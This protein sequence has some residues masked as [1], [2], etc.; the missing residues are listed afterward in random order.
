MAKFAD[1]IKKDKFATAI[2][3]RKKRP[4]RLLVDDS[5]NDDNSVVALSQQKMDELQL[6]RGDTVLLEGKKRRETICIVLADDNCSNER[7]LM[8]RVVRNNLRV[9]S[10]DIVSLQ[11]CSDA[12]DGKR[13]QVVPID[14]TVYGITRNLFE[15]YLKPYFLEAYR[16]VHEGDTF[17]TRAG[18]RAVEFKVIETDPS[19]Y[20]IVAPGTVIR[21]EGNPI[22]RTEEE[23]ASLNEIGFDDIGGLESVKRELQELIQYPVEHPEKFFKFG[24]RPSRGI[25]LYGPPGCGK[26]LLAKAIANE[27]QANFIS[28]KGPRL[29][30]MLMSGESETN[31]RDIFDEA[32]QAAPCILFFDDLDSIARSGSAS[33]SATNRV[34]N[35]ILTE[36]DDMNA[37]Q[38]VFIIGASNR[39]DIIDPA[40]LRSGRLD[41]LIYIPL[42]DENSRMGILKVALRKSPVARDVD[43][44]SLARI[45]QGF[46]SADLIEICQRAC[47]SAIRESIAKDSH[48]EKQQLWRRQT[49]MH[50]DELDPVPEIRHDHFEEAFK[51]ARRS[52]SDNDLRKY[53]MFSQTLQQPRGFDSSFRFPGQQQSLQG[54][55][56]IFS[57][58]IGIYQG[59]IKSKHTYTKEFLVADGQMNILPTAMSLMA[60]IT[61]VASLL[62]VPVQ[63]YYYGTMLAYS[64]ML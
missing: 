10:G 13:I 3:N 51:F 41:Q 42:P 24:M 30:T 9:R 37:E 21:C 7:I 19:P 29:L 63:I 6:F 39:P 14:N 45:T 44:N 34:I 31:V 47:K 64:S 26:T 20:C 61:S 56:R 27:Y 38:N 8:N 25:L 49:V 32:R 50:S 17:I 54:G 23:N 28:V 55:Y 60:S 5:T 11:A 1:P 4:N 59:S 62:G 48:R 15:V 36:M 35:Q 16:A 43:M 46:S 53:Q 2:L 12:K 40:I 33:D 52:V 58:G 18:M 57:G 22:K